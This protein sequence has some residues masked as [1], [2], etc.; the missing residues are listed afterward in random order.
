MNLEHLIQTHGYW[1]LFVGTF[2]E[3]ET[4]LVL[5]GFAAHRGYLQLPWVIAVATVGTMLGDQ[6]F[7]YVGR[8]KGQAFLI[9]RGPH[10]QARALRVRQLLNR[11]GHWA[12]LVFRFFY[13]MR[14]VT[15][16]VI[17]M[18]GYS[19]LRFGILNAIAAIVWAVVVG[20]AGYMFGA[21]LKVILQ[22]VKRYELPIFA[23]IVCVGLLL[24]LLHH[25]RQRK[26]ELPS[27][28]AQSTPESQTPEEPQSHP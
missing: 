3:G 15:P 1:A 12:V 14:T 20:T 11:Y 5:A 26:V 22:R 10:W 4:I 21:A 18:S 28:P 16:F 8:I 6:T 23:A 9:R 24:W 7:F 2:L 13:G 19:P 17:G 27:E 25:L